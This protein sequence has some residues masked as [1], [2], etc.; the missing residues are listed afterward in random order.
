MNGLSA[1]HVSEEIMR[2]N[3]RIA[4]FSRGNTKVVQ[5]EILEKTSASIGSKKGKKE[6]SLVNLAFFL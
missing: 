6:S 3:S 1:T 4:K 2:L 5:V